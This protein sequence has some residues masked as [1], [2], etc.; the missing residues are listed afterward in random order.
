MIL[1]CNIGDCKGSILDKR[2]GTK[3]QQKTNTTSIF[4]EER[5]ARFFSLTN[6]SE[7]ELLTRK[8]SSNYKKPNR[9]LEEEIISY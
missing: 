4:Q 1:K 6:K 7:D 5:L 8:G 3:K 9:V 2:T